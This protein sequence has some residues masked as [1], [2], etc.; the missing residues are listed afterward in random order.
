M[1]LN[2][3][4]HVFFIFFKG[5]T[6]LLFCRYPAVTALGGV[7]HS[8]FLAFRNLRGILTF[9]KRAEEALVA[10]GSDY[11][12]ESALLSALCSICSGYILPNVHCMFHFSM[13]TRK[14]RHMGNGNLKGKIL[15]VGGQEQV[16]FYHPVLATVLKTSN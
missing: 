8:H 9:R 4:R 14:C 13:K 10:S 11:C 2:W 6:S 7:C 1:G 12:T 3:C 16:D 15:P 5:H